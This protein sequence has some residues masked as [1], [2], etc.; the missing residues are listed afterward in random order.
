MKQ[1]LQTLLTGFGAAVFVLLMVGAA[2][3]TK[4]VGTFVGN[5][6]AVTNA[7]GLTLNQLKASVTNVAAGATI[8]AAN[9]GSL[10]NASGTSFDSLGIASYMSSTNTTTNTAGNV[11]IQGSSAY[12][13]WNA[14]GN[15]TGQKWWQW[16][17]G[18]DK[19]VLRRKTDNGETV[20][21]TPIV[22]TNDSVV[23]DQNGIQISSNAISAWPPAPYLPGAVALVVSNGYPYLLLS[24][25]GNGDGSATWTGTNQFGW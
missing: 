25:N 1:R 17:V 3:T 16:Y 22:I 7:A 14:T 4:Y 13:S 19:V 12:H 21:G 10:T 6:A 5:G 15:S 8:G 18:A 9:G 20:L 11:V 2:G 24:T 23:F